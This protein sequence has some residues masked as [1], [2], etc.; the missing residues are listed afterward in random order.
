MRAFILALFIMGFG[1][2]GCSYDSSTE[3]TSGE[4]Q[5]ERQSHPNAASQQQT[6]E[7][8]Q[9]QPRS[10]STS[11][12]LNLMLNHIMICTCVC[13]G[14]SGPIFSQPL[15]SIV[16][17]A[18]ASWSSNGEQILAGIIGYQKGDG[19]LQCGAALNTSTCQIR[20]NDTSVLETGTLKSC[21]GVLPIH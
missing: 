8:L 14:S 20:L 9:T 6:S 16:V 19:S 7:G 2:A 21:T 13:N 15:D 1:L 10:A 3:G 5:S 12:G 11:D 4:N 17:P 18:G